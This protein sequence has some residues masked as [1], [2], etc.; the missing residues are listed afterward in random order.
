M[1]IF[2]FVTCLRRVQTSLVHVV[3]FVVSVLDQISCTFYQYRI[4]S[5]SVDVQSV[6]KLSAK[7]GRL[8]SN[9]SPNTFVSGRNDSHIA[10]NF[11]S[12]HSFDL[13]CLLDLLNYPLEAGV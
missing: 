8:T 10:F 11:G 3:D 5:V 4:K 2:C 12:Q 9:C 13:L 7:D 1:Q 6:P